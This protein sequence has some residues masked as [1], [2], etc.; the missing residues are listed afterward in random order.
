MNKTAFLYL[1][2][3][4]IVASSIFSQQQFSVAIP[5]DGMR[6]QEI[7]ISEDGKQIIAAYDACTIVWDIA[8]REIMRK[9]PR[10]LSYFNQSTITVRALNIDGSILAVG[11]DQT[12]NLYNTANNQLIKQ[13]TVLENREDPNVTDAYGFSTQIGWKQEY[14]KQ[15]Y[16]TPDGKKIIVISDEDRIRYIDL[17]K[18]TITVVNVSDDIPCPSDQGDILDLI[19]T[20]G[21]AAFRQN[22]SIIIYNLFSEQK[23]GEIPLYYNNTDFY[24]ISFSLNSNKNK[25]SVL[26]AG[27]N[28]YE[29][30]LIICDTEKRK[31]LNSRK[32]NFRAHIVKQTNDENIV[33]LALDNSICLYNL[34][35]G[36]EITRLIAYEEPKK[37]VVS[38]VSSPADLKPEKLQFRT[39]QLGSFLSIK[40]AFK[41]INQIEGQGFKPFIERAKING[42]TFWIV[43]INNVPD[44]ETANMSELLNNAGFYDIWLRP[45]ISKSRQ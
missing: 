6:P 11:E 30:F 2:I 24:S 9:I 13:F 29:N 5:N 17:A 31:I 7:K 12:L 18:D 34:Q 32:L 23:E 14:F 26:L 15:I 37:P 20:Q 44:N 36:T 41:Y 27:N 19:I 40:D 25:Q 21:Q 1:L 22:F 35:T 10:H 28:G 38:Q 43:V 4:F 33:A 39:L 3:F 45:D 16:F 42:S 8:K